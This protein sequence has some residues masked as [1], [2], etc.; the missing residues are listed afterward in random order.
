MEM[1]F[2]GRK[3]VRVSYRPHLSAEQRRTVWAGNSTLRAAL[4]LFRRRLRLGLGRATRSRFGFGLGRRLRFW[5][6]LWLLFWLRFW[7]MLRFWLRFGFRFW[8]RLGVGRGLDIRHDLGHVC[9]GRFGWHDFDH[10]RGARESLLSQRISVGERKLDGHL[11][12]VQIDDA[13]T[14]IR[15]RKPKFEERAARHR[16]KYSVAPF[17]TYDKT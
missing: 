10:D 4:S 11:A 8:H 9:G 3:Q 1:T 13:T 2:D 14:R 12:T 5:L 6:R 7:R 15:E 16:K 17:A